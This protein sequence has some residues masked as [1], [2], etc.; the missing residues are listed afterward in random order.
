MLK[1]YT[2]SD[3]LTQ[4]N[5]K[6]IFPLL[7][8]L[9]YI[10][11]KELKR[12]YRPGN[13]NETCDITIY[14]FNIKYLNNIKNKVELDRFIQQAQ[15]YDKKIWVYS[16]GDIGKTL[17]HK[18]VFVFRFG[19]FESKLNKN[20][21]IFPLFFNDPLNKLNKDFKIL[22]KKNNPDIGFVGRAKSGLLNYIKEYILFLKINFERIYYKNQ[23]DYQPFY[24]SSIKRFQYLN[25]FIKD[26]KIN[27][28]F[29]LRNK[30]RAGA[31]NEE[32]RKRTTHEFYENINNNLYTF[33][34][35]GAGNFSVRFYET[36][37]L[38]RIPI[39][40]DTDCRLPLQDQIDWNTHCIL[41]DEKDQSSLPEIVK[42]FHAGLTEEETQ[43]IQLRNRELWKEKLTRNSYF[44]EIHN[45]FTKK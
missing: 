32:D 31:Q 3:Y 44:R 20:T 12:F 39:L 26:K 24:P 7:L 29:I 41:V 37:A 17:H 14:P 25:L 30:Y 8:D 21:F 40:I 16:G 11:N 4:I 36:L 23:S 2:N 38:G 42:E 22:P 5:R 15:K 9:F 34:L 18:N 28:S 45:I 43:R 1:I 33:C 19:G 10:D 27:D 13:N 35:R 6:R